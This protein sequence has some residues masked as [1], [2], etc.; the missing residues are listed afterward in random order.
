MKIAVTAGKF[1]ISVALTLTVTKKL[2]RPALAEGF[3][4]NEIHRLFSCS[5]YLQMNS[6]DECFRHW[7]AA[8]REDFDSNKVVAR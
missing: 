8:H 4:A 5:G 3:F 1:S 7:L 2:R 6:T